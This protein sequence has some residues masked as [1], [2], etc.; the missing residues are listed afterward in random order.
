MLA[1][2][3]FEVAGQRAS[4]GREM[5]AGAG[6]ARGRSAF[7]ESGGP[8]QNS[9]GLQFPRSIPLTPAL[10]LRERENQG[11]RCNNSMRLGSRIWCRRCSLSLR[12]RAGVRGNRSC[13]Y[14]RVATF[15]IATRPSSRCVGFRISTFGFRPLLVFTS[16]ARCAAKPARPKTKQ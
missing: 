13:E 6:S 2:S 7:F 4:G 9:C 16:L 3:Y 10:S 12:E 8:L 11:P 15:A 1:R 14:Q 5:T